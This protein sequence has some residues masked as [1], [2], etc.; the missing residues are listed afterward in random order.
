[1]GACPELKNEFGIGTTGLERL[2][3]FLKSLDNMNDG[4]D[5]LVG[6]DSAVC[7]N[8]KKKWKVMVRGHCIS[9]V[10]TRLSDSTTTNRDITLS[11]RGGGR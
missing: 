11:K 1:M 4:D 2:K 5:H 9:I 6:E 8:Q 3:R 10:Q 7:P